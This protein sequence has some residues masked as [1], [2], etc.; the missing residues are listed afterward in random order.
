MEKGFIQVGALCYQKLRNELIVNTIF[1]HPHRVGSAYRR[2]PCIGIFPRDFIA[3]GTIARR[4]EHSLGL[5]VDDDS[6]LSSEKIAT[7]P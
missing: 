5:F 1:R 6:V 7:V 2:R 3:H 4:T